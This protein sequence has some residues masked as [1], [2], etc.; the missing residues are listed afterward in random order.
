VVKFSEDLVKADDPLKGKAILLLDKI[1]GDATAPAD[2]ERID[3]SH[4]LPDQYR[5]SN[6]AVA[7]HEQRLWSDFWS[8]LHD[9][10]LRASRG[11][12][13][14]HGA[15]VFAPFKPGYRYELTLTPDGN[16][17]LHANEIPAIYR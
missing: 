12:K 3:R 10:S 13:V 5:D 4:D 6:P 9:E 15:G 14:V 7:E 1:Y 8:M 11:V 17:T 16:L 2:A